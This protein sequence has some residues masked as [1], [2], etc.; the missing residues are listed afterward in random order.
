MLLVEIKKKKE[1]GW[2][3]TAGEVLVMSHRIT[4]F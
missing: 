3:Y 1:L 4:D 2:E